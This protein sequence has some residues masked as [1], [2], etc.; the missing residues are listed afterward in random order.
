MNSMVKEN[1]Q[2]NV[3]KILKLA[4][5]LFRTL[6]ASVPRELLELDFTMPQLKIVFMLY[7][8]GPM[9]MSDIASD[10]RVTL[11]TATGLVDRLVDNDMIVRE[12][13]PDDRRVVLCRLS[14]TGH[15]TV[16]R[17]WESARNNVQS[18]LEK[19]DNDTLDKL[20]GVLQTMLVSAEAIAG[21][22]E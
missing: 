13:Q 18:L 11:A 8:A 21:Q 22:N 16:S 15:K 17:I 14:G 2:D 12:S 10:L 19:M 7:I 5:K 20:T 9:R 3:E 4:D 1:R 6:F